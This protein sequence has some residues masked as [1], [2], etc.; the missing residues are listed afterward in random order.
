MEIWID[1]TNLP[2]YE[3]KDIVQIIAA[4]GFSFLDM[5]TSWY[6]EGGLKFGIFGKKGQQL[7]YIGKC[8]THTPGT[9]RMIPSEV[10]NYLAKL[11]SNKPN[12]RSK[13][14]YSVYLN[15]TNYLCEA[16]LAPSIYLTIGE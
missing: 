14:V 1:N 16:G 2:T 6:P 8:S 11:T 3:K 10:L 5:N 9:L 15:H 4:R 12:F 7:K 13:S